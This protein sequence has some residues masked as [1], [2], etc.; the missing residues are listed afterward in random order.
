MTKKKAAKRLVTAK[1]WGI[2]GPNGTLTKFADGNRQYAKDKAYYGCK[3][4]RVTLTA[5]LP[6]KKKARRPR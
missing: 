4:V 5:T 1:S 6:A 2:L 3:I